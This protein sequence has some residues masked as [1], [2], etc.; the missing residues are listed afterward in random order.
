MTPTATSADV[1]ASIT[2]C[3]LP[4]F[5][6]GKRGGVRARHRRRHHSPTICGTCLR[7]QDPSR[8]A[9][10]DHDALLRRSLQVARRLEHRAEVGSGQG[11]VPHQWPEGRKAEEAET[12][13][14]ER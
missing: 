5:S 11:T 7:R 3:V 4:F 14:V 13:L 9:M 8:N 1:G 12:G 6:S 10:Q 2:S